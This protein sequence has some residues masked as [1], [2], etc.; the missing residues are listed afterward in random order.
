MYNL[1]GKSIITLFDLRAEQIN[2]LLKLSSYLKNLKKEKKS[3]QFKKR[4]NIILIFQKDSTRTRCATEVAASDLGINVTF[5]GSSGS[6]IGKKE[7]IK[8][9]ARI[10]GK[11]YDGILYRGY[12]EKDI[13]ELV[14]FS[15]IP[16]WNGLTNNHHPTQILADF[17]TIFEKKKKLKKIKLIYIG[18]CHNN[19]ANSLMIGASKMGMNFIACCPEKLS[20]NMKILK[21]CL[22]ICEESG[23]TIKI[24]KN[25]FEAVIGA[26]VIYTDV[27]SSMG[28][29]FRFKQHIKILKD[30]Q[31]NKLLISKAKKDVIFMHCLPAFHN[32]KTEITKQTGALEV[33]NNVFESKHSV[34]FEQAENRMHTI[35]AIMLATLS[36]ETFDKI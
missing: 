21:K 5:I 1:K 26:D 11:I 36:E 7:S 28:E 18:N 15:R 30:Y 29:E 32:K 13:K 10:L 27:W 2:F 17:L 34:V 3:H 12:K 25:P 24:T 33:T 35:K 31:V 6:H 16:V 20:P 4:K 9:T 23:G 22:K 19:V 14:K 8:D